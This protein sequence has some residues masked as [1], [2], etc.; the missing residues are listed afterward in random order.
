MRLRTNKSFLSRIAGGR[1][2]VR[3]FNNKFVNILVG[4][5]VTRGFRKHAAGAH[6]CNGQQCEEEQGTGGISGKGR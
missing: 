6:G 3:I 4:Q 1:R 2:E 5:D